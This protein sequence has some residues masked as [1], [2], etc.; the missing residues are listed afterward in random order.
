MYYCS[1]SELLE[2]V[3][4][5]LSN[6]PSNLS[7]DLV[8]QVYIQCFVQAGHKQDTVH[9]IIKFK[10]RSMT[11]LGSPVH[12]QSTWHNNPVLNLHLLCESRAAVAH[13]THPVA[14]PAAINLGTIRVT[15][16]EKQVTAQA[17]LCWNLWTPE[18]AGEAEKRVTTWHPQTGA[19]RAFA[20]GG[21]AG[22]GPQGTN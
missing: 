18:Q 7:S 1:F 20:E 12:Y 22:A 6:F 10:G 16:N 9:W 3:D 14:C 5:I 19:F 2:Y 15:S 17:L 11:L 8:W 21:A 4:N 13:I